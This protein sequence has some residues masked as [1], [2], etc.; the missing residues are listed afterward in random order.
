MTGASLLAQGSGSIS[1][2][3][4]P[5]GP[6]TKLHGAPYGVSAHAGD[7][8][9][10]G[11]SVGRSAPYPAPYGRHGQSVPETTNSN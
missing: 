4:R 8:P 9:W 3:A 1:L 2:S 10:R 11:A 5:E 7:D 6:P